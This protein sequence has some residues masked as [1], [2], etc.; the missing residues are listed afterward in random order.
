M[1]RVPR[2]GPLDAV[3]LER[4]GV[5]QPF[6]RK[7]AGGQSLCVVL[8]QEALQHVSGSA[9]S[10]PSSPC[11]GAHGRRDVVLLRRKP[12]DGRAASAACLGLVPAA[13]SQSRH[14]DGVD[15]RPARELHGVKCHLI[16][17]LAQTGG[18]GRMHGGSCTRERS[19]WL[20]LPGKAACWNSGDRDRSQ[21]RGALCWNDTGRAR[22]GR[23]QGRE[24]S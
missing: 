6:G 21:H 22:R 14:A 19:V 18:Q 17:S 23:D 24:P 16:K 9:V 10:A 13:S 12:A 5:E 3:R 8:P 1:P 4:G 20:K 11:W 15:G 7:Q 2:I